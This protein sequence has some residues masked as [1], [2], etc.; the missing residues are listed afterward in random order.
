NRHNNSDCAH[1]LRDTHKIRLAGDVLELIQRDY[2]RHSRRRNCACIPCRA[3]RLDGCAIPFKCLEEAIKI[4]NCLH[5][6]WDPRR[7]VNQ[8]L[9]DLTEAEKEANLE[10]VKENDPVVFDPKIQLGKRTDGFR[11]F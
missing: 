6:K 5:E 9:S 3:D 2:R 4:L 1:C 8:P 7:P 11:I 10:A